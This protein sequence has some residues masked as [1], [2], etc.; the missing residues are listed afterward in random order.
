MLFLIKQIFLSKTLNQ[1]WMNICVVSWHFYVHI[2]NQLPLKYFFSPRKA[3]FAH[4]KGENSAVNWFN[5]FD[6]PESIE[7]NTLSLS[8]QILPALHN[9][10]KHNLSE[11]QKQAEGTVTKKQN[12]HKSYIN[13]KLNGMYVHM[14]WNACLRITTSYNCALPHNTAVHP[15]VH[16]DK[17]LSHA[18]IL[19]F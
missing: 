16:A 2:F 13:I 9:C 18:Y 12:P 10:L 15:R 17:R 7:P 6:S 1:K 11:T 3:F 4:Y 8:S 5:S 19:N 14:F